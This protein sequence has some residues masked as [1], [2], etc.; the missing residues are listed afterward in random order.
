MAI[1]K[2]SQITNVGKDIE[3]RE[4]SFCLGRSVI[5]AAT[6]EYSIKVPQENKFETTIWYR[7][8][9]PRYLFYIPVIYFILLFIYFLWLHLQHLGIPRLGVKLELQLLA[10]A[11]AVGTQDLSHVCY[12]HCS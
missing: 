2:K 9:T 5:G 7:N 10:Y 6:T 8:C 1:F 12:L 11:I 3:E 4:P